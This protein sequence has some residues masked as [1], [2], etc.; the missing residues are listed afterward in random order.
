MT[1]PQPT[2]ARSSL[3]RAITWV[4]RSDEPACTVGVREAVR[5]GS[6]DFAGAAA[7]TVLLGRGDGEALALGDFDAE[8]VGDGD[9]DGEPLRALSG[10][11]RSE[12]STSS[13]GWTAVLSPVPPSGCVPK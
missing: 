5:F 2:V 11:G 8:A 7:T 4:A 12:A 9:G 13:A 1:G 6:G 3:T 10:V